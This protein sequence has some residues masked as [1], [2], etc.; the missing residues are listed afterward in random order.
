MGALL[1]LNMMTQAQLGC[2]RWEMLTMDQRNADLSFFM[3]TQ[4]RWPTPPTLPALGLACEKQ[5]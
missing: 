4:L 5:A 1:V 3:E 2:N